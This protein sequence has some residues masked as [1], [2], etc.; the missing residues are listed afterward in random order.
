MAVSGKPGATFVSPWL[1]AL[2]LT[3]GAPL[4]PSTERALVPSAQ[5][6]RHC[7]IDHTG[8]T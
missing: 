8:Q 3:T 6:V 4:R 1:I 2:H 5:H 7:L